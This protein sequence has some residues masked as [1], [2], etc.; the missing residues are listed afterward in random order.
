MLETLRP[1]TTTI[2]PRAGNGAPRPAA[3]TG[4]RELPTLPAVLFRF[5]GLVA[6]R[7]ATNEQLADV[8]WT[9]PALLSRALSVVNASPA[10]RNLPV[11]H[12]RAAIASLGRERL[13][14]LAYTTPLLRSVE[15]MRMGFHAATFWER[16]LLCATASE[17][18]A[19]Q[20]GLPTPAQYYLAGLFHDIGYLR[21]LQEKPA[22]LRAVIERWSAEPSDLLQMETEAFGLDHCRQGLELAAQLQL[23]VWLRAPI[24][25]HHRATCDSDPLTRITCIAS[26]FCSY[27]GIDFF[28]SRTFSPAVRERQMK[29]IIRGL[30]PELPDGSD[31]EILAATKETVAPVRNW[32]SGMLVELQPGG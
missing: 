15:P 6:D 19:R 27:K 26:A 1:V 5:L 8:I 2:V 18:L 14:H 10:Y 3:G 25:E 23:P 16:A 11:G 20:A 7:S 28:P 17:S 4:W 24:G 21:V 9:D 12:L 13:R 31:S 29:A 22:E 30:L 32:I